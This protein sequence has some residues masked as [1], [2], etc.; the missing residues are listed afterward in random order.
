[1]SQFR[2]RANLRSQIIPQ[3]S[4]ATNNFVRGVL[5]LAVSMFVAG[6]GGAPMKPVKSTPLAGGKSMEKSDAPKGAEAAV[7]QDRCLELLTSAFDTLQPGR[8]G[9]SSTPE[10]SA[11]RLN[12]WITEC[13]AGQ[14]KGTPGILAEDHP[15]IKSLSDERKQTLLQSRVDAGDVELIRDCIIDRKAIDAVTKDSKEDLDRVMRVFYYVVRNISLD[16]F[17]L[18]EPITFTPY[19]ALMFGR[20][21]PEGRA[22]I[23]A[24]MLRQ[25]KI[26]TVIVQPVE[27]SAGAADS[28]E[29]AKS[30]STDAATAKSDAPAKPEAISEKSSSTKS[31]SKPWLVGVLLNKQ[32]YLFDMR[33]GWPIPSAADPGTTPFAMRPATLKEVQ[34]DDSLLRRLDLDAEH[35]YALH[36]SDLKTP[37]IA[38]ISDLRLWSERMRQIQN[39]LPLVNGRTVVVYDAIADANDGKGLLT[40]VTEAGESLWSPNQVSLWT[41]TEAC[42]AATRQRTTMQKNE[43]LA[44][45]FPFDAPIPI[46][47]DMQ[48]L[49]PNKGEP[50][51]SQLKTR[52]A[53]LTGEFSSAIKSYLAVQLAEY[54]PRMPI[55]QKVYDQLVAKAQ[56]QGIAQQNVPTTY[57]IP[58]DMLLMHYR[59]AEDAKYWVAVSQCDL[60][61]YR[62][63]ADTFAEYLKRYGQRGA[64]SQSAG[65][66]RAIALAQGDRLAEAVYSMTPALKLMPENHPQ[67]IGYMLLQNR[68]RAARKASTPEKPEAAK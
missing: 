68:W 9:I 7:A 8:L 22:W 43:I 48:K 23:F 24:N 44:L 55:P 40:R 59:A 47:F 61:D 30:D 13:S 28:A 64:W 51:R 2:S 63:A 57:P 10:F 58:Q 17:V 49:Q 33:L 45:W 26:D 62:A 34:A 27:Q 39:N 65:I 1:M 3:C 18:E 16:L 5:I 41:Y 37:S 60:H 50:G 54:A 12:N 35:P 29:P 42:H 66:M 14:S 6:C 67:W 20:G 25:L 53:Q 52:I 32:V 31:A 19:E 11:E 38:V 15:W 46:D 36:S 4:A 21:T 56:S